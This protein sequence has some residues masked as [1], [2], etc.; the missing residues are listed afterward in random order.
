[1][2]KDLL[3]VAA[4]VRRS[5]SGKE[6]IV[7][8][9]GIGALIA[10][11]FVKRYGY[12]CRGVILSAPVL[13]LAVKVSWAT[14]TF[15]RV[16]AEISPTMNLPKRMNPRFAKQQESNQSVLVEV[17]SKADLVR[18]AFFPKFS[19][20]FANELLQATADAGRRFIEFQGPVL[21]LCP[22]ND[23]IC[24]YAQ[25]KKSAALHSDKN[26]QIRELVKCTHYIFT[27]D[28][29]TRKMAFSYILP[30]LSQIF[31]ESQK[32]SVLADKESE[33]RK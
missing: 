2:V 30:W 4:W 3:Q 29:K 16:M 23:N 22:E 19:T 8:G 9:H 20:V 32:K 21:I 26:V 10:L 11:E 27:E 18:K 24:T 5:E 15:I 14:R 33:I 28:E 31:S 7:L 25:L 13:E 1:L 17:G 6:P 12:L